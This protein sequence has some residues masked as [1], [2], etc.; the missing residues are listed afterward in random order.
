MTDFTR[1][2]SSATI[3]AA[4]DTLLRAC[5]H[6]AAVKPKP[7]RTPFNRFDAEPKRASCE[8]ATHRAALFRV[9]GMRA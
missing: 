2:P 1:K 6:T 9:T 3:A 5:G 4:M 8:R 7:K